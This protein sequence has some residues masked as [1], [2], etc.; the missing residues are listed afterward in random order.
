MMKKIVILLFVLLL[1]CSCSLSD[2]GSEV[3]DMT[4]SRDTKSPVMLKAESEN[5]NIVRLTFSEPVIPYNNSFC[6]YYLE[7]QGCDIILY[8]KGK[9]KAGKSYEIKGRVADLSGNTSFVEVTVWG[10]NEKLASVVINE[11]TTKGNTNNPDRTELLVTESGNL[12]GMCIYD[13]IDS[14]Y[15]TKVMLG[16][17]DVVSG[18]YV[19][20]W[21]TDS[22]P[23]VLDKDSINICAFTDKGLSENNGII[24]LT[25]SPGD[26]A[27]VLD[28]VVYSN[29]E[30][31][32]YE[33]YGTK[34]VYQRVLKAK[35]K[36]YFTS[37]PINASSSTA[38]RSV[39]RNEK[40]GKWY[41]SVTGGATFGKANTS[42][43]Y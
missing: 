5:E 28:C 38:T 14:D 27:K 43:E 23:L 30:S 35:E 29:Q 31:S 22:L 12:N 9:F 8:F 36:G 13:G 3:F 15:R 41:I 39:S 18:Q 7:S 10:C 11:F 42:D 34:E 26:A 4:L 37:K 32:D 2:E 25:S 6:D 16:D 19:V 20:I 21:W 24:T 1:I 17:I 40:T 33:G